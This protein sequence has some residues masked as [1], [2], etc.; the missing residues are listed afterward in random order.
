[1]AIHVVASG[2]TLW[3]IGSRYH[4]S[5]QQVKEMNG[6]TSE[7]LMPG[8]ALYIPT[9]SLP[10]R[11]YTI[12]PGDMLWRIA[13]QFETSI[14]AIYRANPGLIAENLYIGQVL[15]IPTNVR[16]QMETLAFIDAY[17]PSTITER[18]DAYRDQLTYLAVFTYSVHTD[19]TLTDI[20][21]KELIEEIK[22]RNIKP[23]MVI[24]NYES[25]TFSSSLASTVLQPSIRGALIKNI[26]NKLVQK[27]YAGVS[28][29]F[30]FIPP[31][32]RND[33]TAFLQELKRAIGNLTMQVNVFSKST[34]MPTNPFAGAFDYDA[35]G[36]IADVVTVLSYDYG[37]TIGPPDPV[38]PIWWIDQVLRYAISLIPQDKLTMAIP[39]YAYNWA[40]PDT[41]EENAK[42]LSVNAAQNLAL[43]KYAMINYDERG[44]SPYFYYSLG[45]QNHIVWFEDIRSLVA[46]YRLL[47]AFN[48]RGVAYWRFRYDFPQNW[49]YLNQ[50]IQVK[51]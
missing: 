36:Q 28:I 16:Y 1:M 37:Y 49:A 50:N 44:Q 4:V 45:N 24:S 47:E 13:Q 29:D 34:D 15:T 31:S 18:L 32:Q 46:K 22:D 33:F 6:L 42:A 2:D 14:D 39:F 30:E 19:G 10:E 48:L 20:N 27:G 23:L 26:V 3:K 25:G 7:V 8:L 51:K 12:Q 9:Q 43:Q 40:I 38:A 35:I 21:D 5:I 11:Y 41:T 17:I